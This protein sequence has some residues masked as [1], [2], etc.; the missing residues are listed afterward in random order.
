[1]ANKAKRK[2]LEVLLQMSLA[3]LSI[4]GLLLGTIHHEFISLVDSF[5]VL[6]FKTWVQ[7]F[8]AWER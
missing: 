5:Q 8:L 6:H 2:I 4:Q 3:S 7:Q 1:M